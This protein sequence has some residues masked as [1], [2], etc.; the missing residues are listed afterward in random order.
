M[1]D[2]HDRLREL[3]DAAAVAARAPR[4][5]LHAARLRFEEIEAEAPDPPD[6][7]QARDELAIASE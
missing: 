7:R 3:V 5:L 6:L 4:Q 2:H 1:G